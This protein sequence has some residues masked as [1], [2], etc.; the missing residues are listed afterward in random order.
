MLSLLPEPHRRFA[1]WTLATL[2][3]LA[4]WDA[5]GL[6]LPAARLLAGP[7]GFGLQDH[8]FLTRVLHQGVLPLAW[9]LVGWITLGVWW[10][11]LGLRR[12]PA[13]GRLQ[14]AGSTWLA[15]LVIDLMKLASRTSCPWDLTEFGGS[16][17]HVSHWAWGLIDG[18]N[19]HCFPAGHASAGFVFIAGFFAWRRHSPRTAWRWL[20]GALLAGALL[21]LSQQL[22]GAHYLSHTLWT[23][24]IC[25]T[26]AWAVDALPVPLAQRTPVASKVPEAVFLFWVLNLLATTIGE[27]AGDAFSRTLGLG[28]AAASLVLLG[29]FAV[30]L[31]AQ[32]RSRSYRPLAY[33]GLVAA[34]TTAGTTI[35]DYLD[36]TRG[37]GHAS[38]A[39]LLAVALA[40]VL[41]SWR[42][43][44][45]R[46]AFDDIRSMPEELFYW[47]TLLLTSILG[48]A[49]GE[50]IS[51]VT[52][53]VGGVLA[54]SLPLALLA[55][56]HA[57]RALSPVL[58][59]WSAC[60]LTRPLGAVLVDTLTEAHVHGGLALERISA[61]LAIASLI[62]AGTM[63]MS[64]LQQ[65]ASLRYSG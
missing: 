63:L 29:V 39:L 35:A 20:V 7:H 44:V 34:S 40:M 38:T 13:A 2:L 51:D 61:S 30:A 8:W 19:G 22:R 9:L 41:A 33:W 54:L 16:A 28:Y 56:L 55:L 47:A 15:L 12:L 18:G 21:G 36:V 52:G 6:D 25:W 43:S 11:T 4:G 1:L 46:I 59:F 5:S 64:R 27:T 3:L 53:F 37:L 58:L 62:V 48:T 10:P 23:A 60:V 32:L 26:V 49:L 14:L 45:G 24:W 57:R 31:L 17:V 42:R 50:C 65:R